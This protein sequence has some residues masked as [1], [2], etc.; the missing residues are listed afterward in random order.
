[1]LKKISK[2]LTKYALCV[3]IALI[4]ISVAWTIVFYFH[5]KGKEQTTEAKFQSDLNIAL[6]NQV[7]KDIYAII[8]GP[9]YF[10]KKYG[11]S[12]AVPSGRCILEYK[13]SLS[14]GDI[15]SLVDRTIQDNLGIFTDA[16]LKGEPGSGGIRYY[17]SIVIAP[18]KAPLKDKEGQGSSS[19]EEAKNLEQAFKNGFVEKT[20]Y[21]I[22]KDRKVTLYL[23]AKKN[24]A[25]P[26]SLDMELP[27][28]EAFFEDGNNVYNFFTSAPYYND[29]I[30]ERESHIK[31][32][33]EAIK[34]IKFID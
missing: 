10:N 20:E 29:S 22:N 14:D 17:F 30:E 6:S 18:I 12:M 11:F 7:E 34:S 3:I 33:E 16:I 19:R 23:T 9:K 25:W 28:E 4:L 31:I 26:N 5:Y 2:I 21:W 32:M 13:S 15:I 24:E 27:V 8:P 1:M